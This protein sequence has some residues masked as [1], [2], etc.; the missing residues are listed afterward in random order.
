MELLLADSSLRQCK[1]KPRKP[2]GIR[3]QEKCC[4]FLHKYD[5]EHYTSAKSRD[6]EP[7]YVNVNII[8]GC[9]G[10]SL[11]QNDSLGGKYARKHDWF[12]YS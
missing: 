1:C 12:A 9:V 11:A 6:R 8:L 10:F 7:N 4:V 5:L 2:Y 3:L